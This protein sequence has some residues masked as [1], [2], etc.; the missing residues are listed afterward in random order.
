MTD[1]II[2]FATTLDPNGALDVEWP[3][4]TPDAPQMFRFIDGEVPYEVINDTF[5]AEGI[6]KLMELEV[7]VSTQL[8]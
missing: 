8:P 4:Y 1:V 3:A 2:R 7:E 6:R 5:R